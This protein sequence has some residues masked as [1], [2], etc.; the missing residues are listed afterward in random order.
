MKDGLKTFSTLAFR[1]FV[2]AVIGLVIMTA[3]QK[4]TNK[5]EPTSFF[6]YQPLTVLS[7]SMNPIFKTGDMLFVKKVDAA[8]V[9]VDDIITFKESGGNLI[10]HRVVEVLT[11]S[12]SLSFVTKGDNNNRVDDELV[13]AESLLG[14]HTFFVPNAGYLVNALQSPIGMLLIVILPTLGYF[15]IGIFSR[16]RD[17]VDEVTMEGN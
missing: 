5:G 1:L 2:I 8:E 9:K 6:G 17:D 15:A 4:F 7:N 13:K 3:T 12:G 16:K 14:K 10:T 11:D